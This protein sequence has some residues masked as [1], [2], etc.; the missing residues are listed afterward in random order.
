MTGAEHLTFLLEGKDKE[1]LGTTYK[2][3]HDM[4]GKI[5]ECGYFNHVVEEEEEEEV[6]PVAEGRWW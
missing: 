1:I 2:E 3:L 5:E 4:I 6:T